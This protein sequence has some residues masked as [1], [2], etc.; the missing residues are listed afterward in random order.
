[1]ILRYDTTVIG[2]RRLT[3]LTSMMDQFTPEGYIRQGPRADTIKYHR[4]GFQSTVH[5]WQEQRYREP[6][7]GWLPLRPGQEEQRHY[8]L[9]MISVSQRLQSPHAEPAIKFSEQSLTDVKMTKRLL[10]EPPEP[11]APRWIRYDQN[12]QRVVNNYDS[13]DDTRD[14]LKAAGTLT[15]L[16]VFDFKLNDIVRLFYTLITLQLPK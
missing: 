13:Y 6:S 7:T 1:M 15:M 12:L 10:R 3:D 11:R 9:E 14:F 5:P 4:H 16:W 8:L 2:Y